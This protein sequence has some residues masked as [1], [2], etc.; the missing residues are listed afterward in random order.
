MC[1]VSQRWPQ[2]YKDGMG[3]QKMDILTNMSPLFPTY[4]IFFDLAN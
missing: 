2:T 4:H 3:N 1:K